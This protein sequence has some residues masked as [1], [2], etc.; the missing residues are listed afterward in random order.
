MH[1]SRLL[2]LATILVALSLFATISAR[3]QDTWSQRAS[4]TAQNLWGVAYGNNHYLA[5]GEAGTILR[6]SDGTAWAPVVSGS[7]N[8]LL[9]A[10]YGH[11]QWIVVGDA[12]LVLTSPD[13]ETWTARPISGAPRLNAVIAT[14]VGYVTVGEAGRRYY[15]ADGES[16]TALSN[17]TYG[18]T[19]V[20]LRGLVYDEGFVR[21]SGD[22]GFIG[23]DA[24][25]Q[26]GN[27]KG[28][29]TFDND[30]PVALTN[31]VEGLAVA[32]GTR[33]AVG[34]GGVIQ[35]AR[36]TFTWRQ[37]PSGTS[38]GLRAVTSFRGRFLAVG[39]NGTILRSETG[40]TWSALNSGNTQSL[41]AITPGPQGVVVVG[42]QGTILQST[43]A[44]EAPV[45]IRQPE[46]T[47]EIEGGYIALEARA[48]GSEPLSYLWRHDGVPV[49]GANGPLLGLSGLKASQA[50]NY[51]VEISNARGS[52]TSRAAS[53][54]VTPVTTT[55]SPVDA[56][57]QTD[58]FA[59]DGRALLVL[60]DDRILV[61]SNTTTSAAATN[62]P[63]LF[64]LG[65]NGQ[66]DSTFNVGT[67]L[68]TGGTINAL[69][70]QS[71]GRILVGGS[72]TSWNGTPANN[73]VRLL[74]DGQL[75]GT[76]TPPTL[77]ND[78]SILTLQV[79]ADDRI[80]AGKNRVLLANG[81][82]D[83]PTPKPCSPAPTEVFS[84]SSASPTS[85]ASLA[86][87]VPSRFSTPSAV[88][89]PSRPIASTLP[90][91]IA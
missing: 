44:D 36:R 28:T 76:F 53:V 58:G 84:R 67:G 52:A 16:W 22:A 29:V 39:D 2:C 66:P 31:P 3:A 8:W 69:A 61:G 59:A 13:A 42:Y 65:A 6:S 74:A 63:G 86:T 38:A 91:S 19:T 41:V 43:S 54:T 78:E 24:Q 60:P 64:R 79:L 87:R 55:Y 71:D 7:T 12:G 73:L 40:E 32:N 83:P 34:H 56:T 30:V 81:Q 80:I 26:S 49:T 5:V 35:T 1:R 33:V 45:L 11:G 47:K 89:N 23:S 14:P 37:R 20:W 17:A 25:W 10:T 4:G 85:T 46:N 75:D 57:F 72:F 15:S 21:S 90:P 51:T 70:R 68:G 77:A 50:G 48:T 88:S 27:Y 9:A 82:P 62:S 18:G